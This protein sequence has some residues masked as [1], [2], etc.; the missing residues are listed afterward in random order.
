MKTRIR[1]FAIYSV[2]LTSMLFI[3][4]TLLDLFEGT[5]RERM[6]KNA[7]LAVTTGVM[8]SASLTLW[9]KPENRKKE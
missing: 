6:I 3:C 7:I 2:I 1:R 9:L 4:F 8:T 5:A